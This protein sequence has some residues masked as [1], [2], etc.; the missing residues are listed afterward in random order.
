MGGTSRE[1][2][3]ARYLR[4]DLLFP[5]DVIL[6]T[7]AAKVSRGIRVATRGRYSH[8]ALVINQRIWLEALE[9]AVAVTPISIDR[10][11]IDRESP[12]GEGWL[13]DVSASPALDVYRHPAHAHF[14]SPSDP[15]AWVLSN[16]LNFLSLSETLTEY[17]DVRSVLRAVVGRIV[18][19]PGVR[20]LLDAI[21]TAHR[22]EGAGT[23]V[24]GKFCSQLVAAIYGGIEVP[25]FKR[26]RSPGRVSPNALARSL[27]VRQD[28]LVSA[29]RGTC[30][31][32]EAERLHEVNWPATTLSREVVAQVVAGRVRARRLGRET[33]ATT[34]ALVRGTERI[35]SPPKRRRR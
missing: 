19:L 23:L 26:S 30:V 27:L 5:G 8:A 12:I 21:N 14:R 33:A 2:T 28:Q 10:V 17:P 11:I 16:R 32:D 9:D 1:G 25:L 22:G 15:E 29:D 20:H 18:D 13:R 31:S 7:S 35:I 6:S 4:V 3:P 34:E 24:P